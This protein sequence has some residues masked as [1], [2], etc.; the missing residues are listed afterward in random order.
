MRSKTVWALVALNVLLL[1]CLAGQWLKP[2]FAY[3]QAEA[4]VS[5]YILVPGSVQASTAQVVYIV[6][7][8]NGWLSARTSTPQSGAKMV[9]APPI[10]LKSLFDRANN[11][12]TEKPKHG[13]GL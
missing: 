11:A 10:D 9:D 2:N 3:G 6:D 5:D 7:T 1:V 4:R 12:G 13:H 8:Q